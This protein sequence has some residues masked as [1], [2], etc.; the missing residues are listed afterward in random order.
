MY[1]FQYFRFFIISVFE[2]LHVSN[3]HTPHFRFCFWLGISGGIDLLHVFRNLFSDR[4]TV[5]IIVG[6][7]ASRSYLHLRGH[8][9]S[10][11]GFLSRKNI[12]MY[13]C[14]IDG[15]KTSYSEVVLRT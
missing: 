1:R 5:A 14:T 15:G 2:L 11:Q 3:V 6:N 4:T 12:N 13:Y 9:D 8:V 7:Q 10:F